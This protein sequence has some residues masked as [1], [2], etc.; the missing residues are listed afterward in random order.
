[1]LTRWEAREAIIRAK[2]G[3]LPVEVEDVFVPGP[4][5]GKLTAKVA[6]VVK[7]KEVKP[8]VVKPVVALQAAKKVV[9]K[10]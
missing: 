10:K 1:M 7:V 4:P 2:S 3:P 5:A 8:K 9:K 6:E